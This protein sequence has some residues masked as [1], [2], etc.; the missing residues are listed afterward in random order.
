MNARSGL[1]A[2]LAVVGLAIGT[3]FA[4]PPSAPPAQPLDPLPPAETIPAEANETDRVHV[5]L[6]IDACYRRTA[7]RIE[8][9]W[10][11]LQVDIDPSTGRLRST[12]SDRQ[13]YIIPLRS[14]LPQ[15]ERI[16][17]HADETLISSELAQAL[18]DYVEAAGA[19]VHST[20]ALSAY[21][22]AQRY[23]DDDWA[24]G[25]LEVGK[26]AQSYRTWAGAA[27]ALQSKLEPALSDMGHALLADTE[28]GSP[29]RQAMAIV[30]AARA[31]ERCLREDTPDPSRCRTAHQNLRQAEAARPAATDFYFGGQTFERA[32]ERF[33]TE[34]ERAQSALDRGHLRDRERIS[35]QMVS[36]QLAN[37]AG[38]LR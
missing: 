13:P 37:A 2:S 7:H 22:D 24:F 5:L 1:Y 27:N 30:F 12:R 3:C 28:P 29:K 23:A 26:L 10:E 38:S 8:Q 21:F 25:A 18:V 20:N 4:D 35:V 31:F 33:L 11:R 14:E 9:T 6:G 19:V 34:A 17:E 36:R 16:L 15:C 32:T